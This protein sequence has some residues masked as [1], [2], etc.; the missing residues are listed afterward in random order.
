MPTYV[1]AGVWTTERWSTSGF[2]YEV[3]AVSGASIV[4]N[5]IFGDA[6]SGTAAGG[7]RIFDLDVEGTFV[8]NI[9][10]SGTYNPDVVH[11]LTFPVT[12]DGTVDIDFI[13]NGPQNPLV[14]AIEVT[15][16]P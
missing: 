9:D 5:I 2:S 10:L 7:A 11:M 6:Y 8:D 4:V 1:P 14:N 3:P 15:L 16:A 12:S 13:F